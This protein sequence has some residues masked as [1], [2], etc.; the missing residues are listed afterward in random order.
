M[1]SIP[2]N[3]ASLRPDFIPFPEI[4]S[5]WKRFV[6]WMTGTPQT[7][8]WQR[9]PNLRPVEEG[10]DMEEY[11]QGM[12]SH[13]PEPRT[14]M[15]PMHQMHEVIPGPD[16]PALEKEIARDPMAELRAHIRS[17]NYG[18]FKEYCEGTAPTGC[19]DL[20]E[21]MDKVWGWATGGKA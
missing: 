6:S 9:R 4:P 16:L 15:P 12:P 1:T 3:D 19:N 7:Q 8:P 14:K 2:W 13:E 17:L 11:T 18:Q 10:G 20:K 5:L 21:Y